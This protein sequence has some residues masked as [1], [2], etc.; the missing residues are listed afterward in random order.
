[1]R[2]LATYIR[3]HV[4]VPDET[5]RFSLCTRMNCADEQYDL[6][7]HGFFM[8]KFHCD[9]VEGMTWEFLYDYSKEEG[10]FTDR[11]TYYDTYDNNIVIY[12]NA[13]TQG[14]SQTLSFMRRGYVV[15][16]HGGSHFRIPYAQKSEK[17][18][19]K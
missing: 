15:E 7:C 14:T 18:T 17:H 3:T 2:R 1:M 16:I 9:F 19:G 12:N 5:D 6:D 10:E 8:R 4:V 11:Y 13:Y